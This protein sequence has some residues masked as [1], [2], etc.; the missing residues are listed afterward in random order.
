MMNNLFINYSFTYFITDLLYISRG[1]FYTLKLSACSLLFGVLLALIFLPFRKTIFF[2]IIFNRVISLIRGTPL[3]LQLFIV[4]YCGFVS[5]ILFAGVLTFGLNS[6]AYVS[7]IFRSGIASIPKGQFEAAKTLQIPK[8][9]MW[10]A[11]I[12]PQVLRNTFPA[13]GNPNG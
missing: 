2:G 11:I 5:N 1:F 8:F 13:L 10:K 12:L 3:M 4:Y 6:F 7:E 9:Q